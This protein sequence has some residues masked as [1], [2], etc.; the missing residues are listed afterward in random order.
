MAYASRASSKKTRIET[1]VLLERSFKPDFTSRASSKKT[2]I[3]TYLCLILLTGTLSS[4][5][6]SKKTRIE[7]PGKASLI[8]FTSATFEGKFQEN[9]D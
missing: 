6:S 1:Y 5:A 7:T 3:E 9:K 8:A 2:R 4:R